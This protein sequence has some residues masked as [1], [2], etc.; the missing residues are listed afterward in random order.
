MIE[1]AYLRRRPQHR[2]PQFRLPRPQQPNE[3]SRK[4]FVFDDNGALVL[5]RAAISCDRLARVP[6]GISVSWRSGAANK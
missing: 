1:E 6:V 2:S 4:V 5:R 3:R